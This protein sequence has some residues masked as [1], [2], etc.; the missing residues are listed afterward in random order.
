MPRV[1]RRLASFFS[2]VSLMLCVLVAGS[3]LA[4][5][6]N[7]TFLSSRG[8]LHV[9]RVPPDRANPNR[10]SVDVERWVDDDSVRLMIGQHVDE[11]MRM[12]YQP[13]RE[14]PPTWA[15]TGVRFWNAQ[16]FTRRPPQAPSPVTV[17]ILAVSYGWLAAA[18]AVYPVVH[19]VRQAVRVSRERRRRRQ[20]RCAACGYDLRATPGACPE[21][22]AM[23]GAA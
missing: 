5:Y 6:A 4:S 14:T 3:W 22:G 12:N 9:V 10:I 16:G 21:C 15:A 11:G 1:P 18:A 23:P 7:V 13:L 2:L 17:Q 8:I 20:N 19:L